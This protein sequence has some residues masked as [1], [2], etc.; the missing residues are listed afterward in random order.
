VTSGQGVSA[1][2]AAVSAAD[3]RLARALAGLRRR[4]DAG[5]VTVVEALHERARLLEEHLAECRA[6]RREHLG[7]S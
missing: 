2:Y 6:I 3:E 4:E 7:G 5:E 1:Y